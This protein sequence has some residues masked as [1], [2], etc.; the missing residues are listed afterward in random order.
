[1][2]KQKKGA[3]GWNDSATLIM[4]AKRDIMQDFEYYLRAENDA[5]RGKKSDKEMAKK[6]AKG[7]KKAW[8]EEAYYQKQMIKY[9]RQ[10]QQNFK[11]LKADLKKL[12]TSKDYVDLR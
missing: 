4:R 12:D 6:L 9:A 7:D 10:I 1:M 5:I 11:K 8:S 3:T 2:L